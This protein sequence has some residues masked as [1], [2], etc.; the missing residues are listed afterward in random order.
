MK[1]EDWN[2]LMK[3]Y[4]DVVLINGLSRSQINKLNCLCGH[5]GLVHNWIDQWCFG[6]EYSRDSR[7][8]DCKE[9][10]PDNFDWIISEMRS[11]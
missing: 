11:K 4:N 8:C 7:D 5:K 3:D 2:K 6:D 10:R 9:M 1:T